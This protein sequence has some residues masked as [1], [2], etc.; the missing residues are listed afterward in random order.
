LSLPP[1]I[2]REA[3]YRF[4]EW[5][6]LSRHSFFIQLLSLKAF[7]LSSVVIFLSSPAHQAFCVFNDL[8]YINSLQQNI[9]SLQ[10]F[11]EFFS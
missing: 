3:A 5:L 1:E 6:L 9:F 4:R 11:F 8:L 10:R 7:R 2:S